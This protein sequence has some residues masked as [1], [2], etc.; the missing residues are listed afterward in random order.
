MVKMMIE[1]TNEAWLEALKADGEVTEQA[2]Q[3]LRD[4]MLRGI[5]GYLRARSDM[6]K[7]AL[8]DLE[9]LAQDTVQEALLKIQ[10]KLDTFQG[11]SKLTTWATKIAIN[12][13]ISDLRRQ[14]WRDMSLNEVLEGGASLDEVIPAGLTDGNNPA[15]TTERN[16]VWRAVI[17]VLE[18]ELT[19]RQR[20]AI[21]ATQLNGVPMQEAARMLDTNTNNLYKLIHD[22]RLKI[23]RKL[24]DQGLE[25]AY[26]L[27]LFS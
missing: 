8:K 6:A 22:A 20:Q 16:L 19:P 18:N 23:K 1:R 4:F 27:E 26:I 12:H 2:L 5:M 17:G 3:E 13:L 9:Q 15:L 25:L 11:K 10:E 7:L 24:L 21:I 14:R